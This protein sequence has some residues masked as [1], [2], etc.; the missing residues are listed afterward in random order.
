M[1]THPLT[2]PVDAL[3]VGT[4]A[5]GAP[6]AARLAQAGLS[7]VMIE[8]GKHWNP[9][10]DFATDEHEQSKLFWADER[11]S[12]GEDPL[13]FGMN[14]SG[15]GVGG[16]TLHWTAYCPRPQPDDFL[17]KTEFGRGVDWPV[18]FD[19]L[20]PYFTE[21]EDFIGVSGP[22]DYPWGPAR[23]KPYPLPPLP[24]NGAAQL[25]KRGCDA[26]GIR[27]SP[28]ANAALSGPYFQPGVGWRPACTNRGF[29]QA[30]CSTGAKASM[31][32]TY[33]PA[34]LA[35]GA[36]LRSEAFVTN[37][38][39]HHGKVTGVVYSKNGTEHRQLCKNLFLCCGAVETPRL[40]LLNGLCNKSGQVGRHF[41]AHPGVQVWGQFD[42]MIR[43][44]RGIPASLISEDMHRPKD[45]DFAG[46]YLIQS[47]GVM[48]VTY[49]IQVARGRGLWG[50]A[51]KDCV[52]AYNRTAGINVLGEC[53]PYESN[54]LELSDELDPRGLP[55]PKITFTAGESEKNLTA[56]AEKVMRAIWAAA[57]A[58]DVWSFPRYAHTIG[59]CRMGTDSDE[60]VVT[61]EGRAHEIPNLFV[62]DNS[63]FPSSLCVNP[64]LTIMA[65]SLRTADRFLSA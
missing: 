18:P 20:E 36:E 34:A 3:I 7:V 28:A 19:E 54:K 2:D 27:T 58:T 31:D 4:G 33:V 53:L 50:Q 40:L 24:M 32:V 63:I 42:E 29:C 12:A 49:A 45:A 37:I 64:S 22:S 41:T 9:A 39:T 56:H 57:G 35:A 44:H 48:P 25:M 13:A 26:V 30:G 11:L 14:N 15:T 65:L 38:E 6:L 61:P 5:G 51:L 23:K 47:I 59:T 62:A 55:K 21:V 8:A 17:L 43:P 16:G 1:P 52:G 60:S 10:E 46:G